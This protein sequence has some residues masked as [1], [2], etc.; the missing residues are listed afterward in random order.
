MYFLCKRQACGKGVLEQ[1]KHHMWMFQKNKAIKRGLFY[2]SLFLAEYLWIFCIYLLYLIFSFFFP[3]FQSSSRWWQQSK[4]GNQKEH[5]RPNSGQHSHCQHSTSIHNPIS[6]SFPFS[7]ALLYFP[8]VWTVLCLFLMI[9]C[10]LFPT[11]FGFL[12]KKIFTCTTKFKSCIYD[13]D[14]SSVTHVSIF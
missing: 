12:W 2:C 6:Y 3:I 13:G 14:N 5:I 11:W 7:Y 4:T 10:N 1:F 9:S 8:L